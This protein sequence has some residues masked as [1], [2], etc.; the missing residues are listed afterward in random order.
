MA[1][2]KLSIVI[3]VFNEAAT[4]TDLLQ[5]VWAQALPN[6]LKKEMIIVESNSSDDTRK[7]VEHFVN[8]HPATSE[9][10]VKVLLEETPRGKGHAVRFGLKH[11][12]GDI[13]LI[14]DGDL[15]Y[16]V[17]DYPLLLEPLLESHADFVLGSRHLSAG[18]WKI[19]K[20]EGS[21]FKAALLNFG[22]V[23]FK[24]KMS[25]VVAQ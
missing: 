2:Q 16:D 22:G 7:L 6:G 21:P 15:E 19:R 13:V 20:F 18:G 4:V 9:N 23:F 25:N 17:A 1:L 11:I 5:N 3:P 10:S 8:T 12:T 14:Q 24:F